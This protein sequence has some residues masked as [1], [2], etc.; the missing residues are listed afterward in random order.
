MIRVPVSFAMVGSDNLWGVEGPDKQWSPV[1]TT[2]DGCR[3]DVVCQ[4]A[5]KHEGSNLAVVFPCNSTVRLEG[6][7]LPVFDNTTFMVTIFGA[8]FRREPTVL[9]LTV[10]SE[11]SVLQHRVHTAN[12]FSQAVELCAGIGVGT[13]GLKE[14]GIHT[15]VAVEM[16]L[17]F[18]EAYRCFHEGTQVIHGD[19]T[20]DVVTKQTCFAA[21]QPG[22]LIAGFSCQPYSRG[23]MQKGGLDNRSG[24]LGASLRI[25]YLLRIPLVILECVPE[26]ATNRQVRKEIMQFCDQCKYRSSEVFLKLENIWPCRRERWWIVLAA[27]ALGSV[28]LKPLPIANHPSIVRQ[29]L[30]KDLPLNSHDFDQLVL[31]GEEL[32][33][34]CMHQQNLHSML[35]NRGGLSPA[36][37]HSMGSQV[38]GCECGCRQDGFSSNTLSQKG[39]FGHLCLATKVGE[40]PPM[41]EHLF[42][43]PHPDEIAILTL[44][45]IPEKWPGTLRLM[46]AGLG[47]QA[48]PAHVLWIVSQTLAQIEWMINGTSNI[49][50]RQCLDLYLDKMRVQ[51][52]DVV[53]KYFPI[54]AVDDDGEHEHSMLVEPPLAGQPM[55]AAVPPAM[56]FVHL[57]DE[58][59]FTLFADDQATPCV[60]RLASDKLTVGHLRAAEAG[61][62]PA[63]GVLDVLDPLTEEPFMNCELLAGKC[64]LVRPLYLDNEWLVGVDDDQSMEEEQI[65]N[66]PIANDDAISPTIPFLV[67]A[68]ADEGNDSKKLSHCDAIHQSPCAGT[69]QGV[70]LDPLVALSP[71]EFLQLKLPVI[72]TMQAVVSMTLP[73]MTAG[74]RMQVVEAQ[75]DLWA[76]DEIRWHVQRILDGVGNNTRIMLDPLISSA[77]AA[78]GQAGLVYQ[79]YRTLG[80]AP[81]VIATAVMF[82]GH[83]VPIVWTWTS[84]CLTA[85]M[86][87]VQR[88]VPNFNAL[89]DAIAKVVGTRTYI[90]HVLHRQFA[91]THLCGICAVRWIDYYVAGKMLPTSCEEAMQLQVK[92]KTMFQDFIRSQEKVHRPWLWGAGLD[93]HAESRFRELLTQHG[94]PSGQLESRVMLAVQAIGVANLQSA[95]IGSS[96]WRSIKALANQVRPPMQLVLPDELAENLKL[97]AAQGT[98]STKKK[99]KNGTSAKSQPKLPPPLDPAKLLID[100]ASFV[101]GDGKALSQVCTTM[102]G[103][104]AEGVAIATAA[105]IDQ[106]LRNGVVVAPGALGVFVVNSPEPPFDTNL[107]WAQ[108][109]IAMKCATNG[110]PMLVQGILVQL[111]NKMVVQ[112]KQKQAVETGDLQAACVKIT[113]YRDCFPHDW[114]EFLKTPVKFVLNAITPLQLCTQ[115]EGCTCLKWHCD[116][117]SPVRE[118]IFDIWRRQWLNLSF[119]QVAP[120]A[121]DIFAVNVRFD[122][123]IEQSVVG[124]SGTQGVFV[125]PRSVDGKSTNDDFAIIWLPRKTMIEVQH[126]RQTK[127]GIYGIARLGSRWGVRVAA[128]DA[129]RIATELR[130]DIIL[131]QGGDKVEYEIGPIPFGMD[132]AALATMCNNG[133]ESEA[134]QPYPIGR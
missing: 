35:L 77:V 90:T 51:A 118:P 63:S 113:I 46:L 126:L 129:P 49:K 30:P 93:G 124:H 23:G 119:H 45:P 103:P 133:L 25:A 53:A 57:G 41:D 73:Q 123:K 117:Q 107:Q 72:N 70:K 96:P 16:Q 54:N 120:H 88:P 98:T 24:S 14:I 97:K 128:V 38:C 105:D 21:D 81:S 12:D 64:V 91:P 31:K 83:W 101:D 43:H 127:P 61:S 7:N 13:W 34:F 102:L 62:L 95:I 109:R 115:P 116:P 32:R 22:L 55:T 134:Y 108:C 76:D 37:L 9:V 99:G 106:F 2:N 26:A 110:E 71:H 11:S 85:N 69:I 94:V 132:R 39:I 65:C 47:Q 86:W 60:I 5:C 27:A 8:I 66:V 75:H 6:T 104:A 42:R 29:I 50:P 67:V 10:D 4:L 80:V 122:R 52:K 19:F 78:W 130:P 79:W 89:H 100:D 1:L 112:A 114:N 121:A 82:E 36:I 17:P 20:T 74:A 59:S 15:Q 18:V 84:E 40:E 111:G 33:R 125:E 58:M 44:V 92:G 3:C 56:T 68:K 131:L 48:N 87:D 28:C